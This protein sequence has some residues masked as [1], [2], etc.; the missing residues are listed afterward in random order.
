[1]LAGYQT[2]EGIANMRAPCANTNLKPVRIEPKTQA[3]PP[4]PASTAM[5]GLNCKAFRNPEP[6][7]L[8][9]AKDRSQAAAEAH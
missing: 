1:M 9:N 3:S 2:P 6:V 4:M 8:I 7:A 5:D